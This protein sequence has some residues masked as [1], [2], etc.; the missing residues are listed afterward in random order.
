MNAKFLNAKVLNTV[1]MHL[2]HFFIATVVVIGAFQC[3]S[4]I[5]AQRKASIELEV[6]MV[7]AGLDDQQKWGQLLAEVGAD[8][9]RMKTARKNVEVKV[10][11]SSLGG[12]PHYRVIGVL[13]RNRLNLPGGTFTTRDKEKIKAHLKKIREDGPN[14]ALSEKLAF[15][16]TAEQLVALQEDLASEHKTST[17]NQKVAD[18]VNIIAS[19]VKTPIRIDD[20]A[21]EALSGDD[22]I[23]EE[24]QTLTCGTT[25]A[26]IIRP[27]GLVAVPKREQGKEVEIFIVDS[28]KADEHWPVGWPPEGSNYAAVPGMFKRENA[29][30]E[31]FVVKDVLDVIEKT[32]KVPFVYDHNSMARHGVELDKRTVTYKQDRT[33]YYSILVRILA[34]GRP[35]MKIEVR[36]DEASTPFIWITTMRK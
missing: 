17:K 30:I 16:L 33:A 11:E 29:D 2:K 12:R 36:L 22:K 35:Q 6:F 20:S 4:T 18:I 28:R 14:T 34:K 25:L 31:N 9:Y 8:S 24:M 3:P 5:V 13:S 27:I 7:N 23:A 10:D 32:C 21:R 1:S 15:G 26:A 19:K